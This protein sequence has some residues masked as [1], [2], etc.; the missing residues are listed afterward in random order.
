MVYQPSTI[1]TTNSVNLL[2]RANVHQPPP[3]RRF[4][5]QLL[6]HIVGDVITFLG[7]T[8]PSKD[9]TLPLLVSVHNLS[10]YIVLHFLPIGTG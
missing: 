2:L 1:S 7:S 8:G 6:F 3:P 4:N 10:P 9:P 5:F